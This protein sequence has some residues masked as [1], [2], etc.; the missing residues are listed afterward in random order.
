MQYK[1]NAPL[2]V[3]VNLPVEIRRDGLSLVNAELETDSSHI[4][5]SGSLDNLNTPKLAVT[6]NAAISLREM[7]RSLDL[8]IATGRS[9]PSAMILDIDAQ[10]DQKASSFAIQH[11]HL[12][13][14][15]TSL[16]A[17]GTTNPA[18][19]G[20]VK[21]SGEMALEEL[22][23]LFE[24]SSPQIGGY[25]AVNGS[26]GVDGQ[27]HYRAS[28]SIDSRNLSIASSG[29]KLSDVSLSTPFQITPSL[30]SLDSVRL[31]LLGGNISA[32][33]SIIDGNKLS[34]D[35]QMHNISLSALCSALAGRPVNYGASISGTFA[36]MD[37]FQTKA[38][39][40][41][42][43]TTHLS[44]SPDRR[45]IPLNGLIDASYSGDSGLVDLQSSYI[46]FPSSRVSAKGVLNRAM[47][48]SVVSRN[49]NDFRPLANFS[50]NGASP[51][52]PVILAG[53]SLE[54]DANLAGELPSVRI[55]GRAGIRK[56][57]AQNRTF[58]NL[59]MNFAA[60]PA[61]VTI[62]NGQLQRDQMQVSFDG[63]LSLVKWQPVSRSQVSSNI[64]IR[65]ADLGDL[66]A[67]AGDP[68]ANTR[69]GLEADVHIA[70]TYGDPLGYMHAQLSQGVALGQ[71]INSALMQA[72]LTHRLFTLNTLE[73]NTA[74]GKISANAIFQ[75]PADSFT[76]GS[77]NVHLQA[78]GINLSGIA[79]LQ[80]ENAGIQGAVTFSAD[81]AGSLSNRQGQQHIDISNLTADCSASGLRIRNQDAGGLSAKARTSS[82]EV[83]YTA[84]SNFAGST[85][86][87]DG[88]TR[89]SPDYS[90][91][92][93][94]IIR[95]LPIQSALQM[96]GQ[97]GIP[98]AGFLTADAR[99]NG[100]LQSPEAAVDL[101]LTKGNLYREPIDRL[102]AKIAYKSDLLELS[103]L[104]I[105][106]PAG[107]VNL[108]GRYAH[109]NGLKAGTLQLRVVSGDLDTA[110]VKRIQELEPGIAGKITF[111]ANVAANVSETAAHPQVRLS[112]FDADVSTVSLSLGKQNIGGLNFSA[113]TKQSN[114]TFSLNSNLAQTDIHASGTAQ[115]TAN[116]PTHAEVT[117][118]NVRYQNVARLINQ[119]QDMRAPLHALVEGYISVNGPVLNTNLLA[120]KVE[121]SRLE[122]SSNPPSNGSSESV[123]L[124]NDEPV[125]ASLAKGVLNVERFAIRGRDTSLD[126]TGSVDL[127]NPQDALQLN[128]AGS[129]D[130]GILQQMDDDFYSSGKLTLKTDLAGS[131]A[132]PILNGQI[133]LQ[134]ANINYANLPNVI[135]SANGVILLSG[136]TAAVKNLTAES[137]G[138]KL[139]VSGTVGLTP[140][141]LIYNLRAKATHV[142]TRYDNASITS[143]ATITLNGNSGRSVLSGRATVEKLA[144]SSSSDLGS[145]LSSSASPPSMSSEPSALLAG[146]R[147]DIAITTASDLRISSS[148]VEKLD[149]NSNLVVRGTAAE[150]GVLGHLNITDG[151]LVFFGNT[152]NVNT[153]SINFYNASAIRPELNLSLETVA[154]GV[155]IT[156]NVKGPISDMKL[157]YSSDPPLTFE[158]IVQLLATN[159]TPFDPTIAAHQPPEPQ[160][161]A[162]QMGESAVLGQALANPLA[163][164]LQ[165]VFG[166]SQFKIDPS[167]A[168]TN[169]QPTAKVTLSQKIANNITFTYI[170]DV[171]QTNSEIVRVEWDLS[172]KTSA[173][174]LRDY[175]GNVSV[176]LFHKLRVR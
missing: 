176:Q 96:A 175:N 56:F 116:Y 132:S 28:G 170:T 32:R 55:S 34:A 9:G 15:K 120:G 130:L 11:L 111:D 83:A 105:A 54:L 4:R 126:L 148:Y 167:V 158:Q 76:T 115:L 136:K 69:A 31:A 52:L 159:T 24:V 65:K 110:K 72:S 113:R 104:D 109:P 107:S 47:N 98:A 160:Q 125:V 108:S 82:G 137:G 169:G 92:V 43:A 91:S 144:Y 117:F 163:S 6:A 53:G 102:T 133:A 68:A 162:S 79:P 100:N 74:G 42:N 73:L 171:S 142:R 33:V 7:A 51:T 134:N 173:V 157:T 61:G 150:P 49:L 78:A 2:V 161:S 12:A 97:N 46:A 39:S 174:A 99:V 118:K 5:M 93:R 112:S 37:D 29:T 106:A 85:I 156:L 64:T 26:A 80:Q 164:R 45:G 58:D 63:S 87:V 71:P 86:N 3:H 14:G 41:V 67:L 165:R 166:L 90:T 10:L 59:S 147:L 17:A 154:Q 1:G 94:G 140:E 151:Q 23:R 124:K 101:E 143:S 81:L 155:D 121:L 25:L 8:P 75:H 138:G 60:S 27:S 77:A 114:V 30:I 168:G 119:H 16:N 62:Q 40:G 38:R 89:L 22:S 21:F 128:V 50:K 145:L 152:Y 135:S 44:I 123:T 18:T 146:M 66:L 95:N 13:L 70:G 57:A 35:G 19:G 36:A 48:V 153:G 103:Q 127:I 84:S 129:L 20:T 149:V 139:E 88:H 172:A 131:L 122:I 141:Q